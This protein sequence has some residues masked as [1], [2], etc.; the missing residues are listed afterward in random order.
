MGIKDLYHESTDYNCQEASD[1]S[2]IFS[3]TLLRWDFHILNW[4]KF[5][6]GNIATSN[7]ALK[8]RRLEVRSFRTTN[9]NTIIVQS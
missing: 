8:I 3:L 9:G 1:T 5:V 4:F 7:N 6:I 2:V